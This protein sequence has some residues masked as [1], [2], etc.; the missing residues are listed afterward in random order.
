LGVLALLIYAAMSHGLARLFNAAGTYRQLVYCWGVMQLP[1]ILF[2]GL[3][4]YLI[5]SIANAIY[6]M[7]SPD[8]TNYSVLAIILL[9]AVL[10]ALGGIL[11]L[12]YAGLVAFSAVEKFSIGKGLG[13]LILLAFILAIV[14][15]GLSFGFQAMLTDYL[16][17]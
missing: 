3:A 16:R 10:I 14:Y 5:P 6:R 7:I 13:V 12:Y 11:Y 15:A 4:I 2:S 9:I 1:F 8:R 17:Y